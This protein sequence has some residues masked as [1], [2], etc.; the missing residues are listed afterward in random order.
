[1]PPTSPNVVRSLVD[2]EVVVAEDALELDGHSKPGNTTT[3]D[4]NFFGLVH[5][6]SCRFLNLLEFCSEAI[7]G[8]K[9]FSI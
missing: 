6:C 8:G 2:G 7:F 3:E 9:L 5:G 1:M 4:N